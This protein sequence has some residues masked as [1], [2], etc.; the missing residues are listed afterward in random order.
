M[1]NTIPSPPFPERKGKGSLDL[2]VTAEFQL[3]YCESQQFKYTHTH[4]NENKADISG[5]MFN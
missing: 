5:E 1:K 3:T 2:V 4:R